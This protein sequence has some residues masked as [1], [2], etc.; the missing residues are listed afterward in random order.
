MLNIIFSYSIVLLLLIPPTI[1]A[2]VF[3][4]DVNE[5]IPEDVSDLAIEDWK[6][7]IIVEF[8][9]RAGDI[10][11]P[12][13]LSELEPAEIERLY[14]DYYCEVDEMRLELEGELDAY[15]SEH[16]F[17]KSI[18]EW[19]RVANEHNADV[20][21]E[22][23]DG[24]ESLRVKYF[25]HLIDDD[26]EDIKMEENNSVRLGR[27]VLIIVFIACLTA[28][29]LLSVNY[30]ALF[31]GDMKKMDMDRFFILLPLIISMSVV[32]V[33]GF[34]TGDVRYAIF[35]DI[36]LSFIIIIIIENYKIDSK[37]AKKES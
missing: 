30:R 6:R 15:I 2:I 4:T 17:D 12:V 33:G 5:A 34:V 26:R 10:P 8:D 21:K 31:K 19:E 27:L 37:I 20:I 13:A 23:Y 36:I 32:S 18:V 28:I 35:I 3:T 1:N 9:R 24:V 11:E 25:A 16:P 7:Q 29:F 22:Y 14:M